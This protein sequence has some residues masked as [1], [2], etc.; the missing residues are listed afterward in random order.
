MDFM[1]SAMR[2]LDNY[3]TNHIKTKYKGPMKNTRHFVVQRKEWL[4]ECDVYMS[5]TGK[6]RIFDNDKTTKK[7][8]ASMDKVTKEFDDLIAGVSYSTGA[9]EDPNAVMKE[10]LNTLM[11]TV[12]NHKSLMHLKGKIVFR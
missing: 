6:G 5:A 3:R 9:G 2:S 1:T 8:F 11:E 7:I 4:K 10:R 12:D